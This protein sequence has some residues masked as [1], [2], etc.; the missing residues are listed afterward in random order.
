MNRE[1][2]EHILR[3]WEENKY[4]LLSSVFTSSPTTPAI[5]KAMEKVPRN[6]FVPSPYAFIDRAIPIGSGQT[7]SQPGVIARMLYLL[8]LEPHHRV[9][10]VG[11]GS[12]Y[13]TALLCELAREVYSIDIHENLVREAAERLRILGYDNCHL[14][15]GNGCYGWEEHAP[16][17]RIIVSARA[18]EIPPALL[19]Q[20]ADGGIM[21]IPIGGP[22]L[23]FLTKIRKV[24]DRIEKEVDIPVLFVPL[25]C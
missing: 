25:I 18:E 14:K 1:E 11:T 19:K 24:G 23:Q 10:E 4:L 6:L 7:T 3:E 15:V 16:Y 9:L 5:R 20:L 2:L 13:Q 22:E 17:D 21:V 8:E 12:G